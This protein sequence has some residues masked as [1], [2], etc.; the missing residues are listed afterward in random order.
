MSERIGV[1]LTAGV[2]KK[3]RGGDRIEPDLEGKI[4]LLQALDDLAEGRLDKVVVT[5]GAVKFGKGEADYY[6]EYLNRKRQA[7]NPDLPPI[8]SVTKG[9]ETESDLK[10][11]SALIG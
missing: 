8:Q 1:I 10:A 6:A 9:I 7:I 11:V 4:R 5:G 3:T 2:Q